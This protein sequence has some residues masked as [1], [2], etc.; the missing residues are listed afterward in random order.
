ML[1]QTACVGLK[2]KKKF[3]LQCQMDF[4]KGRQNKITL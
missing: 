3:L 2:K 4:G 1:L